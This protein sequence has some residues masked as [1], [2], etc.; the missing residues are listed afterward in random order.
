MIFF[1]NY[2]NERFLIFSHSSMF[3]ID[4]INISVKYEGIIWNKVEHNNYLVMLSLQNEFKIK[5]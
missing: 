5:L 1:L 4:I 3:S 2:I